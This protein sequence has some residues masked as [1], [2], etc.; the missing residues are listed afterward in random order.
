VEVAV[1][2]PATGSVE[3]ETREV[4]G[5]ASHVVL[6]YSAGTAT[7]V[8]RRR[9]PIW[10]L[11]WITFQAPFPYA[12][13]LAALKA[14]QSRRRI[15]GLI[16]KF[17]FGRDAAIRQLVEVAKRKS[18]L[19]VVGASGSGKSSVVQAGLVPRLI[20]APAAGPTTGPVP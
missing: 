11:Y 17:F 18:L 6:D 7:K 1:K 10:I 3:P 9:L 8:Y 12:T 15:A 4:S 20:V 2:G 5:I 16:T 19:A 14:A 13:N